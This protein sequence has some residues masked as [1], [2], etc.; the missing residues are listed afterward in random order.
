MTSDVAKNRRR[1]RRWRA[2]FRKRCEVIK[3]ALL[4][5]VLCGDSCG[6]RSGVKICGREVSILTKD[7]KNYCLQR[8]AASPSDVCSRAREVKRFLRLAHPIFTPSHT[9]LSTSA[10]PAPGNA[11]GER[12]PRQDR[13]SARN[14]SHGSPVRPPAAT[15]VRRDPAS[16]GSRGGRGRRERGGEREPRRHARCLFACSARAATEPPRRGRGARGDIVRRTRH[17]ASAWLPARRLT[18]ANATRGGHVKVADRSRERR[19]VRPLGGLRRP[20]ATST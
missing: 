16:R 19:L 9:P 5:A 12:Q 3:I 8:Q 6:E 18:C 7:K 1:T 13:T 15:R 2:T 17:L 11:D 4:H 10:S 20:A 14:T